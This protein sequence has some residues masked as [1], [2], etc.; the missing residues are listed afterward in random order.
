[1]TT[2]RVRPDAAADVDL[3]A[4]HSARVH[5]YW[6]GGKDN[7]A[8]DRQLGDAM[9]AELPQLPKM[10][11]A[12]RQFLRRVVSHLV[13]D[14]GVD[15]FLDIGAGLPTAS[16][17]HDVATALDPTARVVYVDNDPIVAAHGRALLCDVPGRTAFLG[18][19]VA[20]PAAILTDPLLHATLDLRRPVAVLLLSVLDYF[21]DEAAAR[22]VR[23][24]LAG[25]PPGSYVAVS[26]PTAD[27]DADAAARVV[28][29]AERGGLS[30]VVRTRARFV[31]L[32]DGLD[33]MAPG[34]V[35]M[36]EWRPDGLDAGRRRDPGSVCYWVGLARSLRSSAVG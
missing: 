34:V 28:A 6:L 30:C 14:H 24:L 8:V 25:L 31:A 9:A 2:F 18:A 11:R 36:V 26:Q 7:Y 23:T 4:P 35:P 1:M 13:T 3:S 22:I 5:N 32:F 16:N 20:D 21:A 27:F 19:D 17:T 12:N 33:L 29:V 10:V 15:Q